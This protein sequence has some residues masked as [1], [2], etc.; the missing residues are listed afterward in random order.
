MSIVIKLSD[1]TPAQI[2]HISNDLKVHEKQKFFGKKKNYYAQQ[3]NIKDDIDL[4]F[5]HG[6][7]DNS[8]VRIPYN[9]AIN[10]LGY[11]P[12][13][14]IW[15]RH[16]EYPVKFKG[17]LKDYQR[18]ICAAAGKHL[19]VNNT[20]ILNV[21]ASAGK[22]I[23]ATYLAC[24]TT[25]LRMIVY[26]GPSLGEQWLGT[27]NKFTTRNMFYNSNN[28]NSN[29]NND[30]F[31]MNNNNN[32]LFN[33]NKV[34]DGPARTW[35]VGDKFPNHPIDFILCPITRVEKIDP[36]LL[37]EVGFLIIDEMHLMYTQIRIR[38]ILKVSPRY[39]VACTATLGEKK[40]I[41]H[42][43]CGP[44][45]VFMKSKKPFIVYKY[46]TGIT[47]PEEKNKS[48]TLDWTKYV[49]A[50]TEN[51]IRNEQILGLCVAN[52]N[53]KICVMGWRKEHAHQLADMLRS[54]GQSVDVMAGNVDKCQDTHIL[55]GTISK[56]GTGYDE[57]NKRINFKGQRIDLL[58][59]IGTMANE[60]LIEQTFGRSFRSEFPSIVMMI[61]NNKI[62]H[63]HWDIIE[64]WLISRNG[65]VT[66]VHSKFA[67]MVSNDLLPVHVKN[68]RT[69]KEDMGIVKVWDGKRING[70]KKKE[71]KKSYNSSYHGSAVGENSSSGNNNWN[72]NGNN[73]NWN[74]GN[75]SYA[76][77]EPEKNITLSHIG[78]Q[79]KYTQNEAEAIN[80]VMSTFGDEWFQ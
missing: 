17:Q 4:T 46:Y 18:E 58:I 72:N 43:M 54:I 6:S 53:K 70:P 60:V 59:M 25:Y 74:N 36:R 49:K 16:N 75:Y 45:Y 48:D 76:K 20:A 50:Q 64:G 56:M 78:L 80:N 67:S 40:E 11:N 19:E 7:G 21:F 77:K 69:K 27:I 2:E 73:N 66:E 51:Q 33:M 65:S 63:K 24:K 68:R 38:E 15:A 52:P 44:E 61:D 55:C 31:N 26:P 8:Y 5:Y 37:S 41:T 9:F 57:E 35:T 30:L 14:Q 23:M 12:Q 47:I 13:R 71:G 34:D 3:N 79:G 42:M 22:T 62:A 39:I 32:D 28:S 10:L 29:N 1:L